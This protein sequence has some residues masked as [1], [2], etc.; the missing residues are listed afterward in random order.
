MIR[1]LLAIFLFVFSTKLL[2]VTVLIDPGHGG[3]DHGAKGNYKS[4]KKSLEVLEKDLTLS[5][6]KKVKDL[7]SSLPCLF[8]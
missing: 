5:I 3:D 2:A 4:G 6:A 1:K 7:I 8:N